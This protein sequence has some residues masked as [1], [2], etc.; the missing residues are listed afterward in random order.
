MT[1]TSKSSS[2]TDVRDYFIENAFQERSPEET[3]SVVYTK[4]AATYDKDMVDTKMY[5]PEAVVEEFVKLRLDK[6]VHILDVGAG[7]GCIANL[8][9]KHGYTNIDALDGCIDML[10]IAK[11]RD[12]YRNYF[13]DIISEGKKTP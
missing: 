7:T 5:G 13:I 3:C 6:N 11:S 12:L 2:P 10:E 1:S 9:Q 4:W 8:L